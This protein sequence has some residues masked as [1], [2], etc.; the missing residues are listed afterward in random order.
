MGARWVVYKT[1]RSGWG[2]AV[3]GGACG[4]HTFVQC[5]SAP[6]PESAPSQLALGTPVDD[7]DGL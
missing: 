2:V 6:G 3:L 4:A 1:V 5:L 7:T